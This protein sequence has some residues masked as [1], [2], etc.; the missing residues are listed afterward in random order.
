MNKQDNTEAEASLEKPNREQGNPT[1]LSANGQ[2]RYS[3]RFM[4][5]LATFLLTLSLMLGAGYSFYKESQRIVLEQEV[6][7]LS[8]ESELFK[9]L[10]E[11]VYQ[12]S[13]SDVSFLSG[14]PPIQ[15][16]ILSVRASDQDSQKVWKERLQIIF[17]V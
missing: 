16:I 13:A 5:P 10:F 4:L 3:L 11:R 15:E 14:T 17:S 2:S 8:D 12:E 9:L 7:D 6:E 1:Y